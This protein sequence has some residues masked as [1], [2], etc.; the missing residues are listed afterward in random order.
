MVL[1]QIPWPI[2]FDFLSSFSKKLLTLPHLRYSVKLK[3]YGMHLKVGELLLTLKLLKTYMLFPV[4]FL[5]DAVNKFY[6][7]Y[8]YTELSIWMYQTDPAGPSHL[9]TDLSTHATMPKFDSWA[10]FMSFAP[11]FRKPQQAFLFSRIRA[12]NHPGRGDS[13]RRR[14][15]RWAFG[16]SP[17]PPPT[18][19]YCWP[20][21][22]V[23]LSRGVGTSQ[24]Y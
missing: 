15:G 22:G 19:G 8:S 12:V 3:L 17:S 14:S 20:T 9:P 7:S 21:T 2:I 18:A 11:K 1:S 5:V 23:L 16:G 6:L 13:P 10:V 24:A 4:N